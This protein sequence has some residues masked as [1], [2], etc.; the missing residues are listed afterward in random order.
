MNGNNSRK[1]EKSPCNDCLERKQSC[2]GK[3]EKYKKWKEKLTETNQMKKDYL[4]PPVSK[5]KK[6]RRRIY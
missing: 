4:E 2:W 6:I 3:C 5:Y 1:E